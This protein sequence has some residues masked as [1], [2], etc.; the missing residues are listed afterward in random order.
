MTE[1]NH[2][3]K[4]TGSCELPNPLDFGKEYEL[5]V[6]GQINNI[7]KTDLEDGNFQFTYLLK[8]ITAELAG[9]ADVPLKIKNSHSKRFRSKIVM[10]GRDYE[11]TMDKL[12]ANF[13]EVMEWVDKN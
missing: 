4:L 7:R 8:L 1:N 13:N 6:R 11:S 5:K 9:S 3:L 10:S 2:I 12:L